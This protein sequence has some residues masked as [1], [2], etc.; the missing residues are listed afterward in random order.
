MQ[1]IYE[2]FFSD[3]LDSQSTCMQ[4]PLIIMLLIKLENHLILFHFFLLEAQS[5]AFSYIK[6]Y[7]HRHKQHT[8]LALG[9]SD[10]EN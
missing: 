3:N 1:N 7:G 6:N 2:L 9:D 5:I 10:L 8:F 4:V